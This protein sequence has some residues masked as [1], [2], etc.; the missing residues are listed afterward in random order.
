MNW[1]KRPAV[2]PVPQQ[3][4]V[5]VQKVPTIL[6]KYSYVSPAD[7][8]RRIEAMRHVCNSE[9]FLHC[10]VEYAEIKHLCAAFASALGDTDIADPDAFHAVFGSL[11][12]ED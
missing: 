10:C 7:V 4:V 12:D 11:E 6:H 8:A 2:Q 1:F 5:V 9:N 3:P